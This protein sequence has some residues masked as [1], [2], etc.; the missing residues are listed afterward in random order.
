LGQREELALKTNNN[1]KNSQ[2][3][4]HPA[5]VLQGHPLQKRTEVRW[6]IGVAL[7]ADEIDVFAG[8]YNI[9]A[10]VIALG[11]VANDRF[12]FTTF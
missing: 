1:T 3:L 5:G 9:L 11:G 7:G 8:W 4:T 12:W 6:G 2:T 10:Y